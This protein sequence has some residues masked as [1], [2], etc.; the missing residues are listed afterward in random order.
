MMSRDVQVGDVSVS[1]RVDVVTVDEL[2]IA[3]SDTCLWSLFIST[4]LVYLNAMS[5]RDRTVADHAAHYWT[6]V[7]EGRV[8]CGTGSMRH[9]SLYMMRT[10]S[11]S[12]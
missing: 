9:G 2:A 5:Q 1:L 6:M 11:K 3:T 10:A 7:R 8:S 4:E 12:V